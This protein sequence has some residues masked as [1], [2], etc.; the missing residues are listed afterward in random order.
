MG[1]R[2]QLPEPR[3]KHIMLESTDIRPIKYFN[4]DYLYLFNYY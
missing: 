3:S 2:F 1:T 4:L